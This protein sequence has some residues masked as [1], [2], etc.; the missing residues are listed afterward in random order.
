MISNTY[1]N[2]ILNVAC[3]V[4]GS[5]SLPEYL[6]LGLCSAEPNTSSGVITGE[7]TAAPSYARVPVGGSKHSIKYFGSA[8]GGKISNS[9]EIH[10][11]TAQEDWGT[12]KYFFLSESTT[13]VAILWGKI[14]GDN[15]VEI[16]VTNGEV[17][18][19]FYVGDLKASID[20]E[21]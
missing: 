18:P 13:G 8:S 4:S 14:N 6:Y 19:V 3:G 17:V 21:I 7:P 16:K 11:K 15:G 12:M 10:F 1:A 2:K 20:V 9:T 5:V